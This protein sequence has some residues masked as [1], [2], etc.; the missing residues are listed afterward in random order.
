[1]SIVWTISL[2]LVRNPIDIIEGGCSVGEIWWNGHRHVIYWEEVVDRIICCWLRRT[3]VLNVE[4]G[5][6][7]ARVYDCSP[8]TRYG[9][10][11][12]NIEIVLPTRVANTETTERTPTHSSG[13]RQ[14]CEESYRPIDHSLIVL[15]RFPRQPNYPANPTR[16]LCKGHR[17]V[18]LH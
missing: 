15:D 13:V 17:P 16:I 1:L 6:V 14:V 9:R 10:L 18:R 2:R 3:H 4:N 12:V 11:G 8:T 5:E 7:T